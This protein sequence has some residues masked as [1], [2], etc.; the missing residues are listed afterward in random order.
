[1]LYHM[2]QENKKLFV[3]AA[4]MLVVGLL[5]GGFL[6]MPTAQANTVTDFLDR[7]FPFMAAN[8]STA[9]AGAASST[10]LYAPTNDYEAAVVNAVKQASP[11]VVSITISENVP[12]VEQ[13][14]Y[15][16]F[17]D[18]SPDMQQLF[19]NDFPNM[20]QPCDTG[21]TQLQQVGGGSGF[22]ISSDGL[23]LTNKHVVSDTSASYSVLTN[24]G[25]TY[26]AKVL[27]RDPSQDLAVLK[28]DATGLPTVTLGDSDGV[29][30]GQTAIAIGNA[31]GQFSNTV[32]VGVISGLSRTVTAS[33]PD[34]GAQ[35]TIQGVLQTDA[36]I[37]PGNSGGPLLNLQG[38]VIGINTAIASGAENIGFAIPINQAKRDISSVES[39][40]QIQAP[41]LGVRYI[42]VT[43]TL[44]QQQDLPINY[45][46]LVRGDSTG[47]GVA[48]N[49]P[50]AKAGIQ[51]EDIIESVG[52]QK[53]DADHDLST[54]IN[55]H[56]VG[57][58]VTIVVNRAGKEV[59]LQATLAA[60]P[61][62][63]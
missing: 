58:T 1:M 18:L 32:S 3:V 43:P 35:E 36:A 17:G 28:I 55:G 49:S 31:L 59:T 39:T 26:T 25:K 14:P 30:L 7:I 34:T 42:A 15:N 21:Q 4:A 62:G 22:I 24:D 50:A 40:G 56:S 63:S 61:A 46:A 33:A 12:V 5:V 53:I 44:A 23:I 29:E 16:P 48:P 11:A 19:G 27:A 51:A 13:C 45:G 52:G 9:P 54:V 8:S 6:T 2:D 41:Y 20:T 38:Q 57:D 47:P 10:P 60:R 37:N